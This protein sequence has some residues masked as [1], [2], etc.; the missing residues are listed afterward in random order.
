MNALKTFKPGAGRRG[1]MGMYTPPIMVIGSALILLVVVVV[2]AANNLNREKDYMSRLLMEKGASLIKAFEA[3][4]RTGMMSMQWGERQVQQLLEELSRQQD[5]LYITVTDENG[6]IL[7]DSD[8]ARIGAR[9]PAGNSP[10]SPAPSFG[11]K[12]R[13]TNARGVR[14]FEVYRYFRPFS[15]HATGMPAMGCG[16]S[17]CSPGNYVQKKQSIFL[18]FDVASF[19]VAMNE[20]IRNTVIVSSI[21]ILLGFT[22]FFTLFLTQ[23][24][25][26]TKRQL[27][28]TSAVVDEV[29]A[30]MP[31]GLI[32]TGRHGRIVV[33]N[34]AAEA[35]LGIAFDDARGKPC[36][37]ILPPGLI[38]VLA[39]LKHEERILDREIACEVS[40]RTPV[41]MSITAAAIRNN[42]GEPIGHV[43]IL[44]D[45]A[46]IKQL[47]EAV[48][49][50]EKL[51]TIG[52]LAAG[53][54]HEIRN[55]LSSIK[56]MAT[57]FRNR[58]TEGSEE[59]KT[60]SIMVGEVDRL[61]RAISELL[62]FARP[63]DMNPD[64]TDINR[65][66][67]HSVR[68]IR[69]DAQ[70]KGVRIKLV[71]AENLPA[72][73]VDSDR[74][75]QCLLNLYINGI[76]AMGEGGDLLIRSFA[77]DDKW[78]KVGIKDTGP[79]ILPENIK[80]VFDP[81][82]TTKSAGTGLGLAIVYKIIKAHK[83]KIE[84]ASRR[85][86]GTEF[87][88]DLPVAEEKRGKS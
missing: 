88:I 8:P 44:Y 40:G 50:K 47:R 39:L 18:G 45:L 26:A 57:Y 72:V 4:A 30:N 32:I 25:W 58:F 27:Q 7:A 54:A 68:L 36:E 66:L 77:D 67:D 41:P 17:W 62:E 79:G 53:I 37:S 13:I 83:G 34:S 60:A 2:L 29:V 43:L 10:V 78:I 16:G 81:Y 51:A 35:M 70:S 38:E 64:A 23:G 73:S 11:E 24:Y 1:T 3:G 28:D 63:F 52:N 55:P 74:F 61:N 59:K 19:E 14:A 86:E 31:V 75:L 6:K 22:G 71:K 5:I 80:S 15:N 46:E 82:F 76:Q 49:Q 65:I 87:I 69:N 9:Y 84:V 21:L 48:R 42:D 20:D 33:L 56:G 85:D 12:W